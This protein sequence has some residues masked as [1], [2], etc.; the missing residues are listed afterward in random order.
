MALVKRYDGFCLL[1]S[2]RFT[3]YATSYL[4]VTSGIVAFTTYR[5]SSNP[6]LPLAR[7]NIMERTG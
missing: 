2:Y 5:L 7:H 3:L 6:I 4:H 1:F